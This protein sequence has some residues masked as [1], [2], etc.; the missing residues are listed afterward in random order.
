MAKTNKRPDNLGPRWWEAPGSVRICLLRFDGQVGA[1]VDAEKLVVD[2][3]VV[4]GEV[5]EQLRRIAQ[6]MSLGT[7]ARVVN[8]PDREFRF[9]PVKPGFTREAGSI[10]RR[11]VSPQGVRELGQ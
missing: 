7:R 2:P 9:K 5:A 1:V 3:E 11:Q 10:R 8:Q 6:Q 4:S